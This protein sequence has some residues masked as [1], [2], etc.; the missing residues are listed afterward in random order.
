MDMCTER[1]DTTTENLYQVSDFA[2]YKRGFLQLFGF[3]VS[4]VDYDAE[5]DP[6]VP[7]ANLV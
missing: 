4:G 1:A 2:G 3:E 7:I 5:V 6:V